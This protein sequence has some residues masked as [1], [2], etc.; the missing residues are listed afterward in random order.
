M[1]GNLT[2]EIET[3]VQTF[4]S[5]ITDYC[6]LESVGAQGRMM[7]ETAV[8]NRSN[9]CSAVSKP[10]TRSDGRSQNFPTPLPPLTAVTAHTDRA[11]AEP[12]LGLQG[13]RK[14]APG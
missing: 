5:L 10:K 4:Q 7:G 13:A 1:N 11:R 6:R 9:G 3:Q 2:K 8:S 14:G 12:C